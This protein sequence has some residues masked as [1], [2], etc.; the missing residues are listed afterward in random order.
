MLLHLNGTFFVCASR[1]LHISR[2]SYLY[3]I[4][5]VQTDLPQIAALRLA[6]ENRFGHKIESRYDYTQLGREIEQ[7]TREHIAENTLRRLWGGISG[8]ETVHTRTLDVLSRYAGFGNWAEFCDHLAKEG[9]R[10]SYLLQDS[11]SVRT[12]E[13]TPGDRLRIGW[14]PD[15]ECVIEFQGGNTFRAIDCRNSTLQ[16]GDSFECRILIRDYPLSVDNFV[17]DGKVYPRYVMGQDN[18]LTLLE[19]I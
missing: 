12:D 1:G 6:V 14:L 13:L 18:G 2:F 3:R 8:Y 15:R 16:A 10:E 17:H 9:G 4:M 19:R 5:A 11:H 7:V